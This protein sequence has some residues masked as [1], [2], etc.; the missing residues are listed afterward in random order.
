VQRPPQAALSGEAKADGG[1]VGM[2]AVG[3][4]AAT[5]QSGGTRLTF[6]HFTFMQLAPF[7]ANCSKENH[8][9]ETAN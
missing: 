8:V 4:F 9:N 5:R 3:R 2:C 1:F 6:I 7:I